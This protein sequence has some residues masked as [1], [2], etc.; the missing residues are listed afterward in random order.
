MR[1]C[2]LLSTSILGF[3]LFKTK[4]IGALKK[5]IE[6]VGSK[7][8]IYLLISLQKLRA[9]STF[10]N[11]SKKLEPC[12]RKPRT[13]QNRKNHQKISK[14]LSSENHASE[15]QSVFV[16]N[17][18]INTNSMTFTPLANQLTYDHG[19]HHKLKLDRGYPLKKKYLKRRKAFVSF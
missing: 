6:R 1:D 7:R 2:V 12:I 3:V 18:L 14:T 16:K 19:V 5:I 9:F 17:S 13:G 8:K 11:I 10:Q 15:L 4:R